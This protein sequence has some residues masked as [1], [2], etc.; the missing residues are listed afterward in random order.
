MLRDSIVPE[1]LSARTKGESTH[2]LRIAAGSLLLA[3][4]SF[5]P[6]APAHHNSSAYFDS[7]LE[8]TLQ[9]SVT[10]FDWRNPHSYLYVDV[11]ASD[12]QSGTWRL[13][14]GPVALMRRLGWTN[15]TLKPG[16]EV[17]VTVNPSRN[18]ERSSGLLR[19]IDVAGRDLP[20]ISGEEVVA[21]L[22]GTDTSI[23]LPAARGLAGTWATLIDLE[24]SRAIDF[25]NNPSNHTL[26]SAGTEAVESFDERTMHPGLDCIPYTAP[27][28]M[29][30]PDIKQIEVRQD[31]V[32]IRSEFDGTERTI[33]LN[34]Q[35]LPEEPTL[36]GNSLGRWDDGALLIETSDFL[37]HRMG[38]AFSLPSGADKH[39]SERLELGDDG[40]SL[41]YEFQL[42]D[43]EF[44][45][46][47][48]A[49]EVTWAHRPDLDF[50]MLACSLDNSRL[51]LED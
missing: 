11:A 21:R 24:D 31:V 15:D 37:P 46:E 1:A 32:I 48:L 49:A 10:R 34:S 45:A 23:P 42:S 7:E 6:T 35:D 22:A 14:G 43:P 2:R 30:T 39:L 40:S 17:T 13:E 12:G 20:P 47:P 29:V 16:D 33:Y 25:V 26:T 51:Y 27:V 5:S 36:H 9:G 4:L 28:L 41:T 38:N 19:S 3:F 8:V 50:S 44:M 18:P